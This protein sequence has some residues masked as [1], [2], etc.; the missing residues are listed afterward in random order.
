MSFRLKQKESISDGVRRIADEQLSAAIDSA[1]SSADPPAAIHDIRKRC[2]KL[3]GVIRLARSALGEAYSAENAALRDAARVVSQRRDAA[4]LPNTYDALMEQFGDQLD[5]RAMGQV[6][7]QLTAAKKEV[8]SDEADPEAQLGRIA[9]QLRAIRDR[10]D[11]WPLSDDPGLLWSNVQHVYAR[12]R[13]AMSAAQQKPSPEAFHEWRKRAKYHWYH[14]RLLQNVWKPMMKRRADEAKAL[15]D[16]LGDDHDLAVFAARIESGDDFAVPAETRVVMGTLVDVRRQQLQTKAFPLGQR[17]Y[18]EKPRAFI[19][20]LGGYWD[21]GRS[22]AGKKTIGR[23][24]DLARSA[25][26]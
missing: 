21:A 24:T 9:D 8:D 26:Q 18:Q 14:C 12:G 4:V 19:K 15:S 6:R 20:R 23:R 7:R 5:R 3:R 10:I 22:D 2:K 17:L 11:G 13:H 1:T 25:S 16:L